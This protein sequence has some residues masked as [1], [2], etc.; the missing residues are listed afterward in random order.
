[1]EIDLKNKIAL[2][3]G[4]SRGI[5]KSI[6][7]YLAGLGATV[8]VHYH[9]NIDATEAL[10]KVLPKNNNL[11]HGMVQADLGKPKDIHAMFD[12]IGQAYGKL[13]IL[14]NNAGYRI[15]KPFDDIN[16]Y[17]L[18]RTMQVNFMGGFRCTREAI[19]LMSENARVIFIA[20]VDANRPGAKRTDYG[21]SKAAEIMLMKNLALELS[22]RKILVNAVSPGA[23][24]TDMTSQMKADNGSYER[25]LKGIPLGRFGKVNEIA[26][27]VAFLA[28]DNALYITGSNIV[29]DGG[30]SLMRGY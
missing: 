4:S 25:T 15:P 11:D 23:I 9:N 26:A 13:D 10:L 29:I 19:R 20:S 27:M 17:E 8:I 28:S 6:A 21:S 24:D 16:D 12:F 14:V 30:L 22:N 1:M 2:V 18:E 5:G 3:T 7:E